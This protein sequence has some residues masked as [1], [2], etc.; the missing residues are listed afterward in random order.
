MYKAYA[1]TLGQESS[2]QGAFAPWE[3]LAMSEDSFWL[4]QVAGS[5][6]RGRDELTSRR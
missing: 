5:E 2:T 3:H 1:F 6:E 4:S